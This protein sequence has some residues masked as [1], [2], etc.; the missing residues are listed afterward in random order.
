MRLAAGFLRCVYS[1]S[2]TDCSICSEGYTEQLSFTCSKCSDKSAGS[3]AI[4]VVL[5][6]LG[7]CVVIAVVSYATSGEAGMDTGHGVIERVARFIPLQSI[8]IVIVAWQILTQ[9]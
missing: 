2:L 8:K 6:V 5:A 4:A 9:V 7:F 3:I 1:V